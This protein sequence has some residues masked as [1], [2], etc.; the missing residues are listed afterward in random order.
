MESHKHL[1]DFLESLEDY[2]LAF[3]YKHNLESHLEESKTYIK[4]FIDKKELTP[5]EINRLV[6]EYSRK[7]F[8]DSKTR[9]PRC[10]SD[11][12]QTESHINPITNSIKENFICC[13]VCGL[14]KNQIK[15]PIWKRILAI[16]RGF[17]E[18][19]SL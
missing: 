2:E 10:H 7:K 8:T 9:C 3:L 14:S 12:I 1:K 19:I 4:E 15:I 18:S 17:F 13:N 5:I 6:K 16:I 11:K